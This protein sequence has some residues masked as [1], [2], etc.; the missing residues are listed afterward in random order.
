MEFPHDRSTFTILI[1]VQPIRD[2]ACRIYRWFARDDIVGDEERWRECLVV[3]AEVLDED[4][5]VLSRFPGHSLHLDLRHEVHVPADKL[6]LAYRRL[7]RDLLT[8]TDPT[9]CPTPA[10]PVA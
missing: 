3:E 8:D 5:R 4:A 6:S 1:A 2:G 9:P 10:E 7:M